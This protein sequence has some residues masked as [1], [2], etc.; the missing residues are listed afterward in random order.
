MRDISVTHVVSIRRNKRA[1]PIKNSTR[2]IY[3]NATSASICL[4]LF[5]CES[6]RHFVEVPHEHAMLHIIETSGPKT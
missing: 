4:P 2:C 6:R 1:G 3:L 5:S